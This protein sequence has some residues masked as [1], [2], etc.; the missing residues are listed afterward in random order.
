MDGAP[1][2]PFVAFG[3]DRDGRSTSPDHRHRCFAESPPARGLSRTRRRTA[4]RARSRSAPRSRIGHAARPRTPG[5]RESEPRQP[6]APSG[7]RCRL[8]TSARTTARRHR[9]FR[10]ADPRV[11][12]STEPPV[13]RNPPRDW[14][15][16]PPEPRAPERG[17]RRSPRRPPGA[18][19][20]RPARRPLHRGPGPGRQRGGPARGC[21]AAS[22]DS[23]SGNA[24]HAVAQPAAV[25]AAASARPTA[26]HTRTSRGSPRL[27]PPLHRRRPGPR[28]TAT[29]RRR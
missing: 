16:P 15:A 18:F 21:A 27:G 25:G 22:G 29:R 5:V 9:R 1:A 8:D 14:A 24:G 28:R 10:R 4:C 2:C 6:R 20:V 19:G 26:R 13:G 12:P 11:P 23:D 3:D 17:R 7:R